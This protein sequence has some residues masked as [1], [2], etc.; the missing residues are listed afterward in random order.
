[1]N[2]IALI[3]F[4]IL[5]SVNTNAGN[6]YSNEFYEVYQVVPYSSTSTLYQHMNGSTLIKF[7]EAIE[8]TGAE[9]C[10]EDGIVIRN[11]DEHLLSILLT[12]WASGK[13]MRVYAD[14]SEGGIVNGRC[15]ARAIAVR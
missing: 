9:G 2:K 14:T 3:V 6:A 11:E 1:M 4:I 8:W 12:A 5:I 10:D 7:T 13:K 15:Y